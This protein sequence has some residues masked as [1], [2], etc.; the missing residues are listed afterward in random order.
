MAHSLLLVDDH[1]LFR[2]GMRSVMSHWD[3]IAVVGEAANG[4]E[5]VRLARQ[6]APDLVLM[7]IAMPVL[8]GI[9][10]TRLILRAS[11][12]TRVVML[13]M[14]EDDDDLFE[15]IRAGA[16]LQSAELLENLRRHDPG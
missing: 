11:P 2:E 12:A 10:A 13:T 1:V 5:A 16:L 3:D 9:A 7:D 14:S 8:D 15:A 6:L 4:E